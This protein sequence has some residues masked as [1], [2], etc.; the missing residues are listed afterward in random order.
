M[1]SE[2]IGENGLKGIYF[3]RFPILDLP[4]HLFNAWLKITQENSAFHSPFFSPYFAQAVAEAVSGKC[5]VTV[6]MRR[7][8]A[9]GFFPF[10]FTHIL[11]G[12]AERIGLHLSDHNGIITSEALIPGELAR[13]LQ[14]SGIHQYSFDHLHASQSALGLD[15]SFIRE[16]TTI[17]LPDGFDAYWEEREKIVP[18]FAKDTLRCVQKISKE[19]GELSLQFHSTDVN[20]LDYLIEM[21]RLQYLST[22][23]P[24]SLENA[25][26]KRCLSLLQATQGTEFRG[27]LS[28][29][30]AGNHFISSHFGLMSNGV[31]HYWFP[32][33]DP[34]YSS[35]SPGRLLLYLLAKNAGPL[36]IRCI[37]NG[38]G[39]QRH[40]SD[41]ANKTYRLGVGSFR[42]NTPQC[43][44]LRAQDYFQYRAQRNTL[45]R[46]VR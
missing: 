37:D 14:V 30:Y 34:T 24:N 41:F 19:K 11:L 46:E 20:D 12:R 4:Q 5:F 38:M 31:L 2:K 7:D 35:Y 17:S 32:V 23:V 42:R 8:S 29:V 18:K 33:Y 28:K 39:T 27:V 10:Q 45:L 21:K 15:T 9:V 13:M 22:G 6:K 26:T 36:G 3:R 25:W 44:M 1:T 40:K 43:V 16:G